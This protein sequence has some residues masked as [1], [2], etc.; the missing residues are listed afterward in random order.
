M[1]IIHDDR[2]KSIIGIFEEIRA[3]SA[4]ASRQVGFYARLTDMEG[5]YKFAVRVVLL[6][7]DGEKLIGAVETQ[8]LTVA[9]RLEFVDLA[10]NLPPVPFPTF[11]RYEFQL[12][13]EGVYLGRATLKLVKIDK[14]GSG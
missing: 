5:T 11:G 8:E 12:F 3:P 13:I 10:L 4:P 2:K 6:D 7:G 1:V 14:G 9:D